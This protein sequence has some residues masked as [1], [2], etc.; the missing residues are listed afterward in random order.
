MLAPARAAGANQVA[1]LLERVAAR[2]D[3][4]LA[5]ALLRD[6][7]PLALVR[8][9]SARQALHDYLLAFADNLHH[10]DRTATEK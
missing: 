9:E 6:V 3:T 4:L 2:G 8:D 7:A 10:G 5:S 1:A